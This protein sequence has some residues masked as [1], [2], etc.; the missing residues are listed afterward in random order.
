VALPRLD[1]A[2]EGVYRF[3]SAHFAGSNHYIDEIALN[4]AHLSQVIDARDVGLL[5]RQCT[6]MS[7]R[8]AQ[9]Q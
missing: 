2:F 6:T 1:N 7:V 9:A 5:R 8:T 3:A 4:Y